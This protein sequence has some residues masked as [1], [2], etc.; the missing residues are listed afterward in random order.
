[1][2]KELLNIANELDRRGLL[3]EATAIDSLLKKRATPGEASEAF[4]ESL[5]EAD[6]INSIPPGEVSLKLNYL[7]ISD[8]IGPMPEKKGPITRVTTSNGPITK[9]PN[10]TQ[11]Y[12][13]K[14]YGLWH[15]CGNEWLEWVGSEM[16]QWIGKYIYAI[17]LNEDNILK[18]TNDDEFDA[19]ERTYGS[20]KEYIY[21]G[22]SK[23]DWKKVAQNYGG[24]EI[25]P[26]RHSKR[27]SSDWYYGWD[28]A[29]G[30]T[31][32]SGSIKSLKLIGQA[33]NDSA[34]KRP[35]EDSPKD[36][37]WRGL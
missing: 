23:I 6:E 12:G 17:E 3:N 1:M 8:K 31:W 32:D 9:V 28:V 7:G 16:P 36:W 37:D 34:R 11:S 33:S 5:S 35:S 2:I 25:C 15:G 18:I 21:G 22:V 4:L 26:Y 20:S 24:I 29:S 30:C 10:T 19:F 14:P 27:M 13:F